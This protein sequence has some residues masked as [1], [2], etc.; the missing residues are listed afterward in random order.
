MQFAEK[1]P[2]F[3]QF[4][5][6]FL[7]VI[8]LTSMVLSFTML[9]LAFD[10]EDSLVQDDYYNEGKSINLD[11]HK[12]EQARLRNIKTLISFTQ[13]TITV[14]I[15]NGDI[16]EGAA[17]TLDFFHATQSFKDFA[18]ILLKD[19]NGNY[20]GSFEQA[21]EGKWRVSLH[22]HDDSW[23]IQQ[24]VVLPQSKALVFKP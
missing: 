1:R 19:A 23:K 14:E 13:D 15:V 9:H 21:I 2:W 17:L 20:R 11:L 5:P 8:P 4:W 24:V 7:I 10:G 22:P 3:K 12:V 18:V 16:G 6:W